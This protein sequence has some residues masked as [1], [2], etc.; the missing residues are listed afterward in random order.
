MS[1][2]KIN[3]VL[4]RESVRIAE[5]TMYTVQGKK[6]VWRTVRGRHIFFPEDGSA[7]IG[8]PKAMRR[9]VRKRIGRVLKKVVKKARG[10]FKRQ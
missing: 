1:L 9:T 8:M 4:G 3:D 2:S 6:G 5:E 10:L 7:P